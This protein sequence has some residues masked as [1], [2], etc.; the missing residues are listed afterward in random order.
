MFFNSRRKAIW[1]RVPERQQLKD[2]QTCISIF[3]T[4]L[5]IQRS[6]KE[7]QPRHNNSI[8]SMVISKIYRGIEQP[9]E[10]ETW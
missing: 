5:T 2:E 6:N 4:Y 3:V 9:R 10:K 8:P 1:S 7:L